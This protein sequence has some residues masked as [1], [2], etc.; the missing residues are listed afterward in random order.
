MTQR[1]HR[2][3]IETARRPSAPRAAPAAPLLGLG[4]HALA[5]VLARKPKPT[6]LRADAAIDRFVAKAVAFLARN[7]DGRLV[8]YA[9]YLGAAV[10]EELEKIGCPAVDVSVSK[11][12]FPAAAKFIASDWAM[13]LNPKQFSTRDGVATM[14]DLNADEAALIAGRVVH[15]ARHAEQH[16]RIARLQAA[17][18]Q[19]AGFEMKEDA[20]AAAAA[21]PLDLSKGN[22]Q[23]VK[24]AKEWRTDE[25]GDDA[26]YREAVTEWQGELLPL[27]RLAHAVTA[28]DAAEIRERLGRNLRGW[29][30]PGHA[31]DF[32]RSHL[33]S[34]QARKA[35]QVIADVT[36]ITR[37]FARTEAAFAQL[38]ED[39][40]PAAFKPF[41][42]AFAEL[43]RAVSDAYHDQPVEHDAYDAGTATFH[44]FEK[45]R[46]AKN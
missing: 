11:D 39:A 27:V 5:R 14:G 13:V 34:A 1:E 23:E 30:K 42:D 9:L 24:E 26:T 38:P 17:E 33:A 21:A 41:A 35:T 4:N 19:D 16:F 31:A 3:A 2:V 7:G 22:T 25:I 8:Q 12:D 20:A 29:A 6:G 45:A 36:R 46:A 15:E 10:N 43:Y 32:V 28:K 37:E 40:E 44:A 18:G